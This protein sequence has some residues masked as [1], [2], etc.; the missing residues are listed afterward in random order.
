MRIVIPVMIQNAITSFVNM[1]DNIM[2]GRVGTDTLSGV[3]IVNQ[4]LMIYYLCIFGGL[5]GVGI[6]TAQYYGSGN[7]K[8]VRNTMR[9]QIILAAVLTTAG[10]TVLW[11]F[12]GQLI[13]LYLHTDNGIGN[14]EMTLHYAEK[15]LAVMYAGLLP[16]AVGQVYTG[17]LRAT[18]ET[19]VPMYAGVAA[20]LVNLAGNYTLIYGHFGAPAMGAAGAALATVISRYVECLIV[21]IRTHMRTDRYPFIRGVYRHLFGVPRAE[22]GRIIFGAFPLLFNEALW[23]GAQAALNQCY[24][25]R[26]LSVVAATNISGTLMN[27]FN[28][29]F[30]AMGDG[31]AIIVGQRLG[32]GKKKKARQEAG[33]LTAL[34]VLFASGAAMLMLPVSFVF[35]QIYNTSPEIRSMAGGLIRISALFMPVYAFCHACYFTLRSGGKTWITFLFDSCYVWLISVPA[36]WVLA[37]LTGIPIHM[38]FTIVQCTELLKCMLGWRM[39]VSG[40]WVQNLTK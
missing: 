4:L 28:V 35:P 7:E 33:H 24:S 5:S 12:S 30:I 26:G 11:C 31:I 18:G 40:I 34:S 19:V 15:Y 1:L 20:V 8:G 38:M 27:V 29:S 36:A 21:V 37:N 23:S 32:A 10:F 17:T 22:A 13:S 6:Y 14:A 2:V 3:A 9:L 25:V 39:T 16:F